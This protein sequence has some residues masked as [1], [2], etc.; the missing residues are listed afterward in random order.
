MTFHIDTVHEKKKP[1]LCNSCD[2]SFA[3]RG[4]LN[5]HVATVHEK[6]KSFKCNTCNVTFA[7]KQSLERHVNCARHQSMHEGIKPFRR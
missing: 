2:A 4:N 6:K 3:A 5:K 1:F 7:H